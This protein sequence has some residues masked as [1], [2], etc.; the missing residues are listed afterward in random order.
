MTDPSVTYRVLGASD[1]RVDAY[2][3]ADDYRGRGLNA[4]AMSTWEW[5]VMHP[6]C[7]VRTRCRFVIFEQIPRAE[8]ES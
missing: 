5:N 3:T 7:P 2:A 6:E 8:N 4:G 1:D